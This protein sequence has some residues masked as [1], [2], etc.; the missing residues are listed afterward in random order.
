MPI[1]DLS[2]PIVDDKAAL[3]A[4]IVTPSSPSGARDFRIAF[5]APEPQESPSLAARV[6]SRSPKLPSA[7]TSGGASKP[8]FRPRTLLLLFIPL[9]ILFCHYLTHRIGARRPHLHFDAHTQGGV[10]GVADGRASGWFDMNDYWDGRHA[11]DFVIEE[12]EEHPVPMQ[13]ML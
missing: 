12:V 9:F 2:K 3:P 8:L 5:L 4:I 13:P 7:S 11:R 1:T 6:F 10:I